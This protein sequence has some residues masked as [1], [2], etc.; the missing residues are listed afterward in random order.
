MSQEKPI[1]VVALGGH[2]FMRHGKGATHEE[3]QI[4]AQIISDILME[5]IE[6]QYNVIVTHGNGPQVGNL[7]IQNELSQ[8]QVPSQPLD[9]LV[10]MT[11][12]S[13]GYIMQQSLLNELKKRHISRYVVT[14]ITQVIVDEDDQ[15]FKNPTKPIGP[16]LSEGEA[17]RRRDELGWNVTEDSGRGWRRIVPSPLPM[18]V[19]QRHTIRD[20]A[21]Q[22]HIVIAA[23]GG[24]I[25][26]VKRKDDDGNTQYHGVEAVI[27]KDLTS[28]LLAKQV[29]AELLI[30]LTDV[31]QV[32]INYNKEN[33]Q[34]L[35]A[36]T[37]EM[38]EKFQNDGHFAAGSMGP[39]I[40]AVLNFL[41]DGGKRALITS[42]SHL[43]EA[44]AGMT[45][46]HFVGKI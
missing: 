39:K 24:G 31:E 16:F 34:P 3:H 35:G 26:V 21:K 36:L 45:G 22:G 32:Y 37:I 30:I 2:A 17:K 46:T 14:K 28:A 18:K 23:G 43:R 27:D 5:L 11:E 33:Q 42:P 15:A 44:L 10:A 9:V 4:S 12:G 8:S 40:S 13:L 7:L 19:I 25:P 41:K 6:R 20:A 1:V 38:I 29:G